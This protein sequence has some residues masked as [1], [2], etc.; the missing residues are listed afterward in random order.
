MSAPPKKPFFQVSDVARTTA[1][2]AWQLFNHC[3]NI[4]QVLLA[5]TSSH[6]GDDGTPRIGAAWLAEMLVT[7]SNQKESCKPKNLWVFFLSCSTTWWKSTTSAPRGRTWWSWRTGM[8]VG[9]GCLLVSWL[10][11]S[12][13]SIHSYQWLIILLLGKESYTQWGK[14]WST[15]SNSTGSILHLT[16]KRAK[17][18]QYWFLRI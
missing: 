12:T 3:S 15:S 17:T 18:L 14:S 5:T 7:K 2:T 10:L 4:G 8:V 11:A 9:R 1:T 13:A 16:A 6:D